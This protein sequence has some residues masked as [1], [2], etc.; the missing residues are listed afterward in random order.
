MNY[1]EAVLELEEKSILGRVGSAIQGAVRG[2]LDYLPFT[3]K[4]QA[5]NYIRS[6]VYPSLSAIGKQLRDA[7]RRLS[8]GRL[9]RKDLDK[10]F[11][12]A[13]FSDFQAAMEG[14]FD[15]YEEKS[16][17]E[18]A[19]F[20]LANKIMRSAGALMNVAEM[21]YD[22]RNELRQRQA[23]DPEKVGKMLEAMLQQ[24]NSLQS[25]FRDIEK[26]V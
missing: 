6:E 17:A 26:G 20:P 1:T 3:D 2:A 22:Y 18:K 5:R 8:R 7:R 10:F 13:Q 11:R 24:N 19:A 16:G 9:T 21:L 12:E 4:A 25:M 14:F 15:G 23:A